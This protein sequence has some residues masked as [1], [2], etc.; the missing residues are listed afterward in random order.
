MRRSGQGHT[1]SSVRDIL[2]TARP[3]Q[4]SDAHAEPKFHKLCFVACPE[5]VADDLTGG[6]IDPGF[7]GGDPFSLQDGG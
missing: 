1:I 7:L 3:P 5:H 4:W 6:G 2:H